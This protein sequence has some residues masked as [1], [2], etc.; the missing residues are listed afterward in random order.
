MFL[1]IQKTSQESVSTLFSESI[2]DLK[3][4][5]EIRRMFRKHFVNLNK[6]EG[7]FFRRVPHDET[8][9]FIREQSCSLFDRKRKLSR[10]DDDS[11][12]GNLWN[13]WNLFMLVLRQ[14]YEV[15][16]FDHCVRIHPI[17]NILSRIEYFVEG[18]GDEEAHAAWGSDNTNKLARFVYSPRRGCEHTKTNIF[19]F[20]TSEIVAFYRDLQTRSKFI[21]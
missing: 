20:I 14:R 6:S 3:I 18:N 1:R 19:A 13:L 9:W 12:R 17:D 5:W 7:I 16:P 8:D 21:K 15:S 2:L 11:R 4:D 10:R